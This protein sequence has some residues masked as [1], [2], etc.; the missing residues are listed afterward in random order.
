MVGIP[1][2]CWLLFTVFDFGNIDQLFAFLGIV[3]VLLNF[4]TWKDRFPVMILSFIMMLSPLISRML[5]A[6]IEMFNYL[7]FKIPLTIFIIFYSAL[8]I[9]NVKKKR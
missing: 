5:Q 1:F 6:P 7:A 9:L 8:I 4:T 2:A 3:G